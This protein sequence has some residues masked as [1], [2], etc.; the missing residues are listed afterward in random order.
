MTREHVPRCGRRR[1]APAA[2]FTDDVEFSAEDATR[3]DL[4][5]LCRVVER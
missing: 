2:P 1:R 3:S 4:D 5:F